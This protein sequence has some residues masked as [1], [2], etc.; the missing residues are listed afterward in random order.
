LSLLAGLV[1]PDEGLPVAEGGQGAIH[2]AIRFTLQNSIILNKYL[3]PASHVANPGNKDALIQ[4]PMGARFRLKA[5]VNIALLNPESRVIAQ[6]MKDYGLIVADNGSNFFFTGAS[7]AVDG[8]NH[9]ALTWNDGDIQD[10]LHGLKSLHF[11][12]FEMVDLTPAVTNLSV[13][14]GPAG[15]PI[16]IIGRNFSGAAGHLQVFFGTQPASSFT[17]VDDGHI[18]AIA[19]GGIGTVDVRVQ[20]GVNVPPNAANVKNNIFGYGM[21]AMNGA[22]KFTLGGANQP[23]TVVIKAHP[24]VSA[25]TGLKTTLSVQG[26][27]DGGEAQL[28]YSW[29]VLSKPPDAVDPTFSVNGTNAAKNTVVTFHKAGIYRFRATITDAQGLT[30]TSDVSVTVKQTLT[31]ISVTPPSATLAVHSQ[32]QLLATAFDQFGDSLIVQPAF[33]WRVRGYGRVTS[34]GLYYAPT[35]A[36]G[37][38]YVDAVV[39]VHYGT[40]TV[41]IV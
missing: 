32:T 7:Y 40:A 27:D 10:S 26:Q 1:R 3:Y 34:A 22:D 38:N 39:G 30:A 6:A 23:P 17:I 19:P 35:R 37:P 8:D 33:Y 36:G 4:P 28:A 20:S 5:G 41:Y 16:T 13:H 15:T 21:S 18:F 9:V 12:D 31:T 14:Y 25:V 29:S 2:H 11:A 24:W